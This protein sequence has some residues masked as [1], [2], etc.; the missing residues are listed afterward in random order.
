MDL[1]GISYCSFLAF[2]IQS[3]V[4]VMTLP[5]DGWSWLTV[6]FKLFE[7]SQSVGT[8]DAPAVNYKFEEKGEIGALIT[9]GFMEVVNNGYQRRLSHD[10]YKKAEALKRSKGLG[11]GHTCAAVL[12]ENGM[13]T[14]YIQA[15]LGH[16]SLESTQIYTRVSIRK[17]KALHTA[18]HPGKLIGD[19]QRGRML[20]HV[21]QLFVVLEPRDFVFVQKDAK[22]SLRISTV[23][24]GGHAY[25]GER[26]EGGPLQEF[27]RS[28]QPLIREVRGK[29]L[30]E[31]RLLMKPKA[32]QTSPDPRPQASQD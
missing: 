32:A 27:V 21:G 2:G 25:Q 7:R 4:Q 14:R 15:I 18:T 17:L 5:E 16:A 8:D 11:E 13:D 31:S 3:S 29:F 22:F 1:K 23:L 9:K 28:T 12:L 20:A 26:P 10:G 24:Y 6:P 30:E 19:R